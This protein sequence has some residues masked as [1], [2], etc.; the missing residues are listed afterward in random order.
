MKIKKITRQRLKIF[1]EKHASHDRTLDIGCGDNYYVNLFPNKISL[2]ID[3]KRKPD[4]VADVY[5]LPFVDNEFDIILCTEVLEHLIYPSCAI[6]EM[7]RVLKPGGK[8]ILT[9]RFV[10]PLHDA[11]GDYFRY[12]KYGLTELFKDWQIES[13][14]AETQSLEAMAVLMQRLIFQIRYYGNKI[15]KILLLC[16]TKLFL[17]LNKFVKQEFGDIKQT[18]RETSILTSGYYLIAINTK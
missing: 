2:D 10:F 6:S 13:I 18:Q 16:L 4:I 11:P 8:L 15:I 5:N 1:L 17:C 12:T 3:S 14:T 7:R 9:T